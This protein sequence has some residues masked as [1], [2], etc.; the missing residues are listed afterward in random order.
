[1]RRIKI[2]L[3]IMV[4]F[5]IV[6]GALAFKASKGSVIYCANLNNFGAIAGGHNCPRLINSTFT[7][8]DFR[9]AIISYCSTGNLNINST[10]SI[11]VSQTG[12]L[13]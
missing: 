10:C 4:S 1:M 6:G 3:F 12:T 13:D 5:A 8:T 2:M 11:W 9:P 7:T